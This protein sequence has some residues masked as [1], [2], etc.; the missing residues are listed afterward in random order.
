MTPAECD[1]LLANP[2]LLRAALE[3]NGLCAPPD[4]GSEGSL[5]GALAGALHTLLATHPRLWS[6]FSTPAQQRTAW[7]FAPKPNR[8]ALLPP[9][10]LERLSLYWSAAVRAEELARI[11]EKTR[12]APIMAE[13]GTEVYRYAVRRGRFQLGGLR[14]LLRREE[15]A[16]ATAWRGETFR[17]PGDAML[18]RCFA[19]WPESLRAA[20]TERWRRPL[21]E[22]SARPS[23]VSFSALWFWLEKILLREVA[24]EWQPCFNS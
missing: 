14:P 8:L 10:L 22:A 15:S 6:C 12:L 2:A 9:P 24:P 3:F 11:I 4:L 19:R 18:S 13:I 1:S 17:Q 16:D 20:W 23:A 7:D 5:S 21:P